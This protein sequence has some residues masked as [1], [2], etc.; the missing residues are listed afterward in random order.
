MP[1]AVPLHRLRERRAQSQALAVSADQTVQLARA[2]LAACVPI[3]LPAPVQLHELE[4]QIHALRQ[5]YDAA[6]EK[7]A[8]FTLRVASRS[9]QLERIEA[10]LQEMDPHP[11]NL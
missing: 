1:R 5:Q 6:T 4:A 11:R 3:I 2:A 8:Y 10:W 7:A 9:R